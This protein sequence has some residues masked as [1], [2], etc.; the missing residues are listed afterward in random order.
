MKISQTYGYHV[1]A[2]SGRGGRCNMTNPTNPTDHRDFKD[3]V[4]PN[5][6]AE[7]FTSADSS[8]PSSAHEAST[9]SSGLPTYS[10]PYQPPQHQG[11]EGYSGVNAGAVDHKSTMALVAFIFGLLCIPTAIVGLSIVP[12]VIGVI[13]AIIALVRNQK[14]SAPARR[15]WMS[16]TGLVLSVLGIVAS[17]VIVGAIA[18]IFGSDEVKACSDLPRDQQEQC[19]KDAVSS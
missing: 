18:S 16:V 7:D 1:P 4:N 17:I 6:S 15:T 12:G 13:L 19:L 2:I 9:S 14:K 11:L 8:D 3:P 10:A 5:N